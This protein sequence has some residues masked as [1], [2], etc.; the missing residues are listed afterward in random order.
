MNIFT[1]SSARGADKKW[2]P[3]HSK[4]PLF[5]FLNN[6]HSS[7]ELQQLAYI[8]G[9]LFAT[10]DI[11]IPELHISIP[12]LFET[13]NNCCAILLAISNRNLES[14][15]ENHLKKSFTKITNTIIS[16]IRTVNHDRNR[17]TGVSFEGTG[18][19]VIS[20]DR[21]NNIITHAI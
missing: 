5:V 9:Y 16:Q 13:D 17:I 19:R 3:K 11:P 1:K 2:A 21:N 4:L 12:L 15:Q 7:W 18:G 10:I 6:V 20:G 14:Y 8:P